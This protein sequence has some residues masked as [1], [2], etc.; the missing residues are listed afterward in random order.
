M[1]WL[2]N[3][4]IWIAFAVGMLAMHLFGHSGHGGY[5]GRSRH[6]SHDDVIS[7]KENSNGTHTQ[8]RI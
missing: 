8:R 6:G 1:E 5:G 2:A 4:W 3:N 7:I